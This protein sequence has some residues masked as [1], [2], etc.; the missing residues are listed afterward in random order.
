MISDII[1]DDIPPQMKILNTF[2]SILMHFCGFVAN[3]SVASRIK[4]HV[5]QRY[6]NISG[7][8]QAYC[9]K[10]LT[11]SNQMSRYKVKCIRMFA[12]KNAINLLSSD[13]LQHKLSRCHIDFS[14]FH[15]SV[16]I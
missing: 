6:V 13:I 8:I 2:I 15:H 12:D 11:L 1:S 9:R 14:L 16:L 4:P 3:L 7:R 10:F 5:I